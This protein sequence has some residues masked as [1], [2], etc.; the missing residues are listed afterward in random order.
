MARMRTTVAWIVAGLI[1][2]G[3]AAVRLFYTWRSSTKPVVLIGAV[4]RDDSDPRKQSPLA[5]ATLTVISGSENETAKSDTSGLF[6]LRVHPGLVPGRPMLLRVQHTDYKPAVISAT[7]RDHIYVVRLEPRVPE[8]VIPVSHSDH[9]EN[10]AKPAQIRNVKLRY[11]LKTQK[12]VTVG[13]L[14]KQFEVVNTGNVLCNGDRPCS[15]D[16]KWKAFIG[17]L[18]LDAQKGNEFRNVRVTCIAGP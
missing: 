1:I 13:S 11:S 3:A 14:A 4:L 15:P 10:K 18:P 6:H 17:R 2:A 7:T 8:P 9:S 5:N 16:G 12:T